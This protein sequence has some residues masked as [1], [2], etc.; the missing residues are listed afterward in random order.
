[1]TKPI[2]DGFTAI[3]PHLV[4]KGAA[5]AIEFYGKA[6][7]AEATTRSVVPGTD[8]VILHATVMIGGSPVMLNDE[9]PE[10]GVFGPGDT[11]AVTV[12]IYTTDVDAAYKRAVDAGC[13]VVMP[14][15]TMFWGSR[16]AI[17]KDPFGHRWSMATQVEDVDPTEMEAR[18]KSA[19]GGGD[20]GG[21]S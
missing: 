3:T 10:F 8:D 11:S 16:Y 19:F 12:H 7:G 9:M 15:D 17:L 13:E 14:L 6:F 20:A 5:K 4:V 1:M 2:P 21:A 18:T